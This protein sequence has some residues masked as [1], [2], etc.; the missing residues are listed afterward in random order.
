MVQCYYCGWSNPYDLEV[1]HVVPRSRGGPTVGW[2]LVWACKW[3]N[4]QKGDKTGG[5]YVAWR[6]QFPG[7]A[8]H[9]PY[10]G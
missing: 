4:R 5:E 10:P 1:D 2:N 6:S 7:L 3:C 9:G 8:T